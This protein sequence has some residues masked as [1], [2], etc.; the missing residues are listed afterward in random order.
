MKE[1]TKYCLNCGDRMVGRSDKKFCSDECRTM[2]NNRKYRDIH[3]EVARIDRI[4]KKN[5][6]I[7]DTLYKK[8]ERRIAFT[9]LFGMGFNFEYVTSMRESS[10]IDSS[11]VAGCYNYSYVI[12][13]DGVVSIQK[14]DATQVR[15]C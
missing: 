10:D 8:G 1:E 2:F 4:L 6:S 3:R 9:A 11:F 7:I 12:G 15:S 5:Y 14:R 13:F